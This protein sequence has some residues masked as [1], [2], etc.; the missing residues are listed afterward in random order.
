MKT[1][2]TPARL[3]KYLAQTLLKAYPSRDDL[4]VFCEQSARY[5]FKSIAVN[6]AMVAAC[7]EYL[8]DSDV[9]VC[10]TTG[11]PLGQTAI[12]VKLY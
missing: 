10:A 11:F 2:L 6:S 9:L 8:G 12:D 3:A 1:E 5:N 4:R 7:R